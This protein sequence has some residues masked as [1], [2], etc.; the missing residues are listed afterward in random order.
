[1][2]RC[3]CLEYWKTSSIV[4]C[5]AKFA[6]GC[7]LF[8][9]FYSHLPWLMWLMTDHSVSSYWR[10]KVVRWSCLFEVWRTW[11]CDVQ[12]HSVR[13]T[14]CLICW[15][16]VSF[17]NFTRS[18]DYRCIFASSI[19]VKRWAWCYFLSQLRFY[20]LFYEECAV[21]RRHDKRW[22]NRTL[23]D[24]RWCDRTWHDTLWSRIIYCI[25]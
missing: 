13:R 2:R 5:S 4:A 17:D 19:V 15:H 18:P 21:Y 10:S 25:V 23:H 20:F 9:V 11:C 14:C 6:L 3:I 16:N 22:S 12:Q 1:M 24:R 8:S 7:K